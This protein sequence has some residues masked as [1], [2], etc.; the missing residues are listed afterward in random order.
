MREVGVGEK[1][2]QFALTELL[3]RS[4][5]ASIFKATDTESG[6]TVVLKLPHPQYESD[7]VFFERFRREELLGQRLEHPYVIKMLKPPA[8]SRM[9]IAMEYI[10]GRS[11]RAELQAK[12]ALPTARALEIARQVVEALVYLHANGV[13]HR[14]I[15]PENILLVGEHGLKI[16]DFGIALDESARRLT[17]TGLS[18]TIGTPDYMAPEQ[19]GGRRG[20]ARTD[21]YSAG[22][23]LYEMLTGELP[24]AGPSAQALMRAKATEE[25]TPPS[26]HLPTI[27]PA[28]EMIILRAI[29]RAPRDRYATA[30]DLLAD[31]RDPA[32][33]ALRA[34]EEERARAQARARPLRRLIF[35]GAVVALLIG[36]GALVWVSHRTADVSVTA[37]SARGR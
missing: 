19:V 22:M 9:Y 26:Y 15:K 23:L 11:L 33:A 5:M 34:P 24:Y 13:V 10:D 30:Q 35:P 27:D 3:A 1:I 16:L 37:P 7:V 2:D 31:L 18:A 32:A 25:P 8:K 36:L 21:V 14:D 4:G 12:R 29:A 17:W 6:Q 20:D 28:L